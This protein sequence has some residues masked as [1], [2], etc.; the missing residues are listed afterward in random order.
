MAS[1]SFDRSFLDHGSWM[2]QAAQFFAAAEVLVTDFSLLAG[3]PQTELSLARRVGCMKATLLLLAVAVENALKAVRV[4]G[5]HIVIENGRVKRSSLGGG[6]A[7]H[8]LSQLAREVGMI[9]SESEHDLLVRLTTIALWAGK[10]QQ[11]LNDADY[12]HSRNY[13]PRTIT[14]PDDMTTVRSILR[15][16]E[17]LVPRALNRH[18]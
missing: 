1:F 12:Q 17:E 7:G 16:C 2:R 8:D 6:A 5:G 15:K 11:P 18:R 14:L 10:Y 9:V 4:A 13:N 3:S